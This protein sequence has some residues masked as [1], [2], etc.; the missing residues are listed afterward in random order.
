MLAQGIVD[1]YGQL[2]ETIND[3]SIRPSLV[4][5]RDTYVGVLGII[6]RYSNSAASDDGNAEIDSLIQDE[7]FLAAQNAV[8]DWVFRNCG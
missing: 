4:V 3:P 7:D 1:I 2:I 6:N 8:G 5:Q